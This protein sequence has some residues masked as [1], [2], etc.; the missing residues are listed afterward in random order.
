ML[1]VKVNTRILCIKNLFILTF[2]LNAVYFK[3]WHTVNLEIKVLGNIEMCLKRNSGIPRVLG[4]KL[5]GTS[6]SLLSL[7]DPPEEQLHSITAVAS[8]IVRYNF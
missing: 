3:A 5:L 6:A 8:L 7:L 1:R 2:S 4:S